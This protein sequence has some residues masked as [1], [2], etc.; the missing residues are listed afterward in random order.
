M[1][2]FCA[3]VIFTYAF[4]RASEL[5]GDNF[6]YLLQA[7]LLLLLSGAIVVSYIILFPLATAV[8]GQPAEYVPRMHK[9]LETFNMGQKWPELGFDKDFFSAGVSTKVIQGH[10]PNKFNIAHCSERLFCDT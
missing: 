3:G 4:E 9:Y 2:T 7:I 5:V 6:K 1:R 8:Q 10:F